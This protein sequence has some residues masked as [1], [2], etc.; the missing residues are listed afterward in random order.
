MCQ[1]R[2]GKGTGWGVRQ[3]GH[4]PGRRRAAR[5]GAIT[6]C[7]WP[8]NEPPI[9]AHDW[10]HLCCSPALQTRIPRH[11]GA[12]SLIQDGA[13]VA[14]AL[15]VNGALLVQYPHFTGGETE[16]LVHTTKA[17]SSPGLLVSPLHLFSFFFFFF[18]K[19]LLKFV[20][21]LSTKGFLVVFELNTIP[22]LRQA[23]LD[24]ISSY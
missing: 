16:A 9:S 15:E 14:T 22:L 3:P 17:R 19:C 7:F 23:G 20:L 18:W 21:Y 11:Q 6:V 24:L 1:A 2:V 10:Q 4:Q 5:M 13:L 8:S 12:H